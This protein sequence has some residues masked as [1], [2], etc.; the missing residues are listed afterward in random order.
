M[1]GKSVGRWVYLATLVLALVVGLV[2]LGEW[3]FLLLAVL[4]FVGGWLNIEKDRETGYFVFAV[5]FFLFHDALDPVPFVGSY[6]TAIFGAM[7]VA[8]GGAAL[9]AA[10]K[11]LYRWAVE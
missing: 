10:V 2:N 4:G 11:A 8:A 7:L 9:A 5:A 1:K 6:L 3:A